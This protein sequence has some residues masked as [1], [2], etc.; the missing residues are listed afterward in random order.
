MLPRSLF[1]AKAT[2]G[3]VTDAI[4]TALEQSG[5]VE[6]SFFLSPSGDVILV[7]RLERMND[8]GSAPKDGERWSTGATES[9][10]LASL[11]GGL[12]YAD[13]G[14]YRIIVFVL[15]DRP[16]TQSKQQVSETQAQAWLRAGANAL[17]L[18]IAVG[19]YGDGNCTA[20]I[21]EFLSDGATTRLVDSKLNGKQHLEKSGILAAIEKPN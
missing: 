14:H 11:L 13:R 3:Q 5:Y 18:E 4:Q 1:D 16:F 2:L 8:D 9:M 17:P 20:L 19:K 15:G 12:F 10:D 21:Y 6:R 7:T